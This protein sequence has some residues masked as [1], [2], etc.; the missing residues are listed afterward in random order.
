MKGVVDSGASNDFLR[1]IEI[2]STWTSSFFRFASG[3]V[4]QIPD[5]VC[6]VTDL[7]RS[8]VVNSVG[9]ISFLCVVGIILLYQ[10]TRLVKF[11]CEKS[12]ASQCSLL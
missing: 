12:V 7:F 3:R 1:L 5:S 8:S 10:V 4:G 11:W 6:V 9:S 2:V